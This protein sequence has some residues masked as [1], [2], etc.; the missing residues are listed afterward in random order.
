V[1]FALIQAERAWPVSVQ[2]EVLGVSRSGFYAWCSEPISARDARDAALLPKI[3]AAFRVGEE[4]Y[5]SPRITK[6]LHDNGEAV[7]KGVV[8]RVM[9]DNGITP[10]R[11]R[12]FIATTNSN[13]E[14]PIAPN[15]LER[16]FAATR[17]DTVW[18]TDVTYVRTHEG[19]LYLAVILDLFSRR[20]VAWAAGAN[21]DTQLALTAL[22]RAY[23]ARRP[24]KGLIHHSDR[25]STYASQ[26]YREALEACGA[27]QSMSKKGDCWD[28]AVAESFFA[29]IKRE[30]LDRTIYSSR[31]AAVRAIGLYIDEFYNVKR[32]HSTIGYVSPIAFE[33]NSLSKSIESMAA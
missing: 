27:K 26:S 3:Q 21:N 15:L 10:E 33:L 23:D 14:D 17:P 12:R 7:S 18:V 13:H 24:S 31:S 32:R 25:G 1:K 2:C 20:V 16:D 4:A 29:S 8:E 22:T 9:R 19:W 5:G 6:E 11:K 30:R 28:N